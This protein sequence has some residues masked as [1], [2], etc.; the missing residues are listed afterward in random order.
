MRTAPSLFGCWG[1]GSCMDSCLLS[2]EEDGAFLWDDD[3]LI[4]LIGY[5]LAENVLNFLTERF[6]QLLKVEVGQR[7]SRKLTHDLNSNVLLVKYSEEDLKESEGTQ[8]V[9]P[10]E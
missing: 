1:G 2:I 5:V 6:V 9:D 3:D 8:F 7:I 4:E 10:S